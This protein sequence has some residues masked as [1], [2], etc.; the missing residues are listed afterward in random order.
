MRVVVTGSSGFIGC[1]VVAALAR[2]GHYVIGISREANS[3]HA[4]ENH[5]CEIESIEAREAAATGEYI[6]HL[7]ALSDASL[8]MS[9]PLLYNRVNAGG[10][11]N[12]LEAARQSRSGFILAS[13]Q[14]I[15]RPQ[16]EPLKEELTAGPVD[17]YGYS[18]VVA[19]KWVEMY[20]RFYGLRTTVARLFS[21]YGVGQRPGK[22][23]SGVVALFV[24]KA[25][26]GE[27]MVVDSRT[28]RDFTYVAD[29]VRGLRS[30]IEAPDPAGKTYNIATGI[31]YSL[32]ELASQVREACGSPSGIVHIGDCGEGQNYIADLSRATEDLG[33]RPTI[34]LRQGLRLYVDWMRTPG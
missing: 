7:A 4:A 30:I 24:A 11:L 18:K 6:V 2:D 1:N 26:A 8:S 3:P 21:V 27:H 5:L 9:Q 12:M 20:G 25:L 10:T 17:P 29:V 22:G 28:R 33:Y 32:A 14:R 16:P 19:E 31:G 13:T 34:D 15:Y 23:L